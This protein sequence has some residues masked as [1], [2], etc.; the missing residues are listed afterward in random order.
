MFKPGLEIFL[1]IHSLPSILCQEH[2]FHLFFNMMQFESREVM[3]QDWPASGWKAFCLLQNALKWWGL[4]LRPAHWRQTVNSAMLLIKNPCGD[5]L[6]LLHTVRRIA[7]RGIAAMSTN[8]VDQRIILLPF[9]VWRT[10]FSFSFFPFILHLS[11][12]K[13][14]II[15][16]VSYISD[17]LGIERLHVIYA[18]NQL[19]VHTMRLPDTCLSN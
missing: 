3:G 19:K 18:R 8:S 12:A 7:V 6:Q 17:L 14:Q 5:N 15:Y 10:L 4:Y 2:G 16:D 9:Y 11:Q 1:V 13:I